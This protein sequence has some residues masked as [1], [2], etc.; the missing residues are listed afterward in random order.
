MA[1]CLPVALCFEAVNNSG[2][3]DIYCFVKMMPLN[4]ILNMKRNQ[5]ICRVLGRRSETSQ[6]IQALERVK[7]NEVGNARC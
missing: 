3:A 1:M 4:N 2:L 5:F 7:K 6:L